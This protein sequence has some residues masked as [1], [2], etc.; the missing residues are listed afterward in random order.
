MKDQKNILNYGFLMFLLVVGIFSFF[1]NDDA[2]VNAINSLSLPIF[3]FTLSTLLVKSTKYIKDSFSKAISYQD[4]LISTVEETIKLREE[5]IAI[6]K[7][8]GEEIA[9]DDEKLSKS[10]EKSIH[11][12]AYS[13][14]LHKF[15]IFTNKVTTIIN[16]L[17]AV[18]F[19]FCLLSLIGVVPFYNNFYWINI[20]SLM[21]VFFDFFI[22]DDI[23]KFV[24]DKLL[25][26]IREKSEK[27]VKKD[28]EE[29]KS[30]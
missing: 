4:E 25:K 15:V 3:L 9:E 23:M 8:Y 26:R 30:T 22:F 20:F 10:Y 19:A 2:F 11:F 27:K 29:S 5:T 1:K 14:R 16:F 24:C 12:W 7:K 13:N 6:K 21:V 28:I 17:A 18:S